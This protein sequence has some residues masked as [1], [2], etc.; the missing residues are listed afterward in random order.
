MQQQ[1][2]DSVAYL[3]PARPAYRFRAGI[4]RDMAPA[5]T[6]AG[7]NPPYGGVINYF[8]KAEISKDKIGLVVLDSDGKQVRKLKPTGKPGINRLA[9]NLRYEPVLK[10]ALRTTPPG[11]PHIWEEKRFAG[12]EARPIFY[13]GVGRQDI[14]APLVP[15]GTYTIKLDVAGQTLTQKMTV[16]KDPN[17][18]ATEHDVTDSSS[19]SYKIYTDAN[20]SA[21]LINQ[22]EWTRKQLEDTRK[23][24]LENKADKSLLE[25]T[26]KLDEQYLAA[27]NK[28]MHPTIAEG[29]E[30]SFRGPLGL[31]LK[32]IWLGA[33][34]GT[35]GGDVSG[36]SDFKPTQPELEVFDLLHK[37][38]EEVKAAIDDLNAH[39]TAT[40]NNTLQGA[41]VLRIVTVKPQ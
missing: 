10:V 40:Y 5:G 28:L 6:S 7:K 1:V 35:G 14:D 13:Y 4:K 29:D 33:E 36:N 34:A 39:A 24:L 32:F 26:A 17:T 38:L 11:N 22:I 3:F 2:K 18:G 19:F 37:Q 21:R 16:L 15:P 41:G 31:Y 30:K 8:L 23:I 25:V 9:W 27:E 12:K 20:E